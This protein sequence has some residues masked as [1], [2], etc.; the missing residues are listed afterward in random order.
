MVQ[1]FK[2]QWY[3]C[4]NLM[5]LSRVKNSLNSDSGWKDEGLKVVEFGE[6]SVSPKFDINFANY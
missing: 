5:N 1:T 6:K 4:P 2:G 3:Q